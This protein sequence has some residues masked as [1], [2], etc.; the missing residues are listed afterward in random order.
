MFFKKVGNVE[1]KV[2]EFEGFRKVRVLEEVVEVM[3]FIERVGR[4]KDGSWV[5]F[6]FF[7]IIYGNCFVCEK[8]DKKSLFSV[9]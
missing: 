7:F 8:I 5:R 2:G 9:R 1:K 6:T 3:K 4:V